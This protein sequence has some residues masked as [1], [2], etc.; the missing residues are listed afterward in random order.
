MNVASKFHLVVEQ[1]GEGGNIYCVPGLSAENVESDI[2]FNKLLCSHTC[3]HMEAVAVDDDEEAV[4][5]LNAIAEKLDVEN[6][7]KQLW[8][9][10]HSIVWSAFQLGRKYPKAEKVS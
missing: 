8:T 2:K 4:A 9:A 5:A 6:Q 7:D 1:D 10:I 3:L